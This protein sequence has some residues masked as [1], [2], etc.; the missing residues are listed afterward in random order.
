M[1]TNLLQEQILFRPWHKVITY[2]GTVMHVAASACLHEGGRDCNKIISTSCAS[3][4]LAH[5]QQQHQRLDELQMTM[6]ANEL[7]I[8]TVHILHGIILIGY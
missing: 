1:C 2:P 6:T 7:H 4:C 8:L 5:I 3:T